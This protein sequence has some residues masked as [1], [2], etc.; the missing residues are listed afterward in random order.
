M[1]DDQA[2]ERMRCRLA[3]FGQKTDAKRDGNEQQGE[4]GRPCCSY[5]Q[6]EVV[7]FL[8]R[9]DHLNKPRCF[10]SPDAS[11]SLTSIGPELS[12]RFRGHAIPE[13]VEIPIVEE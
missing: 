6:V 4:Q 3:L 5:Q 8:Q 7:P 2:H 11:A 12:S 13:L 9:F 1:D 10:H